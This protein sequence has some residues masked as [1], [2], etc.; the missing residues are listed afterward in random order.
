MFGMCSLVRTLFFFNPPMAGCLPVTQ[1]KLEKNGYFNR[2][3]ESF[4]VEYLKIEWV[5]KEN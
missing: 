4:D 3:H 5:D 2:G 1:S